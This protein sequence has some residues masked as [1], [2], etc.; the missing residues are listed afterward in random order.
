MQIFSTKMGKIGTLKTAIILRKNL[1]TSTSMKHLR[2]V[3][4]SLLGRDAVIEAASRNSSIPR[5]YVG[6]CF[7]ALAQEMKNFVMNGH[8]VHLDRLGTIS[9]TVRSK[10][11]SDD[12]D[13]T[14]DDIRQVK[15]QF[16]PSVKI[17]SYVKK[18]NINW[19][20]P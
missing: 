13:I 8:S 6:M 18:E 15:F 7:D 11:E 20:L 2:I 16:R 17:K 12:E 19:V 14:T 5:A 10:G 3:L 4:Y 9:S 1:K